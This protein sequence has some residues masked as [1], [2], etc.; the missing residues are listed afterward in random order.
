[1]H[2][3][4]VKDFPTLDLG[5][6]R[7]GE[8]FTRIIENIV[9]HPGGSIPQHNE[10]WYDTKATYEFFKNEGITQEAINTAIS[11]FGATQVKQ[12]QLLVIHDTS[13]PLTLGLLLRWHTKNKD[14]ILEDGILEIPVTRY[15]KGVRVI[16]KPFGEIK[17]GNHYKSFPFFGVFCSEVLLSSPV[18]VVA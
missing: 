4:T 16:R 3:I 6:K 18:L 11:A 14:A 10:R 5:D 12:Q 13:T 15:F 8:R 1:M 17:S 9:R 7:R 2:K